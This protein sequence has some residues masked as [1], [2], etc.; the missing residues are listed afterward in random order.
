MCTISKQNENRIGTVNVHS[1]ESTKGS[2]ENESPEIV[3]RE[4]APKPKVEHLMVESGHLAIIDVYMLANKQVR[5]KLEG[6]TSVESRQLAEVVAEY[7]GVVLPVADR[8]YLVL[9]DP[10]VS[11]VALV[12][13]NETFS[14]D[15]PPSATDV[16]DQ[17]ARAVEPVGE[18][19]IDTRCVVFL[20]AALLLNAALL[21]EF[22]AMRARGEE[23]QSR[24]FLREAG[25]A[26]RYGFSKTDDH[27]AV[28][29][30]PRDGATLIGL[31]PFAD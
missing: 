30:Y 28:V 25:A 17:A 9:R 13:I 18:V 26:V 10:M 7:G 1:E 23:K 12:P 20:D 15:A 5:A 11:A 16:V 6:A 19:T 8:E 27:L 14:A 31:W 3:E 24:D 29:Q 2:M 4:E 22:A 21:D